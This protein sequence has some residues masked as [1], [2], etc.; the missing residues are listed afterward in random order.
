MVNTDKTKIVVFRKKGPVKPSEKWKYNHTDIEVVDDFNYLGSTFNFTG[1]FLLNNSCLTGKA[2]TSMY[3]LLNNVQYLKVQPDIVL[4]LFD[5]F[6][7][8]ILNYACPVWGFTKSKELEHVLLAFCKSILGAKKRTSNAA[9][10][11]WRTWAL[12][13]IH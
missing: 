10:Y 13:F 8:S 6:V 1:S 9:R 5:S 4:Q 2:M 12:L 11:L 3:V 7:G